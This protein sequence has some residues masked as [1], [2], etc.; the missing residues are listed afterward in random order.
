ME[1]QLLLS[2]KNIAYV[3]NG[4]E[5]IMKESQ[6]NHFTPWYTAEKYL[7]GLHF[8]FSSTREE[9][10]KK[11]HKQLTCCRRLFCIKSIDL[12]EDAT[13][14]LHHDDDDIEIE[15]KRIDERSLIVHIRNS[16]DMGENSRLFRKSIE[17]FYANVP[18]VKPGSIHQL[19]A[20][21]PPM[22]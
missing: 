2:H 13:N 22:Y 1:S 3:Y 5:E 9:I 14:S 11:K 7:E 4:D 17:L 10:K 16:D 20:S 18:T 6:E 15:I 19:I 12:S 21:V 8:A